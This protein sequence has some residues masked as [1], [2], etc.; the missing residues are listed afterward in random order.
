MVPPVE[1]PSEKHKS[2]I[3]CIIRFLIILVIPILV[4]LGIFVIKI[5]IQAPKARQENDKFV[6]S[7]G[8]LVNLCDD[9]PQQPTGRWEDI[10]QPERLL[11]ME[12]K[13]EP[14]TDKDDD[15][16]YEIHNFLTGDLEETRIARSGDE[17]DAVLC[18]Y[19]TSE[20]FE[21]CE[22]TGGRVH[23]RIKDKVSVAIVNP[24]TGELIDGLLLIGGTPEECPFT[25]HD[26]N[27]IHYEHSFDNGDIVQA[28]DE[29]AAEKLGAAS[30]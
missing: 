16:V 5:A 14:Y 30:E 13:D 15:S 6:E 26:N 3:T 12:L 25:A 22:Y 20:I 11:I 1:D 19:N 7:L 18:V 23:Y 28:V 17:V 4:A 27:V 24:D 29:L 2:S 10:G 21:T 8:D 9:L